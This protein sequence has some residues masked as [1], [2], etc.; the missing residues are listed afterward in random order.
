MGGTFSPFNIQRQ[1]DHQC[2]DS[3]TDGERRK[4]PHSTIFHVDMVELGWRA[5]AN[6]SHIGWDLVMSHRHGGETSWL[7]GAGSAG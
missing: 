3:G 7:L 2:G 6:Q 4:T 1:N 5:M